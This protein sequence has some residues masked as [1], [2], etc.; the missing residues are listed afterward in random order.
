MVRPAQDTR[1]RRTRYAGGVRFCSALLASSILGAACSGDGA[2]GEPVQTG[3]VTVTVLVGG[4]PAA[5]E[6]VVF[7]DADGNVLEHLVTGSDGSGSVSRVIDRG[8]MV[9]AAHV[10]E[11]GDRELV[12]LANLAPLEDLRFEFFSWDEPVVTTAEISAELFPGATDYVAHYPCGLSLSTD[13]SFSPDLEADCL[14]AGGR[15]DVGVTAE[16]DVG[17]PVAWTVRT[18][19][20][21]VEAGTTTVAMPPWRSD[22]DAQDFEISSEPPT[23]TPGTLI[24]ATL[25][26]RHVEVASTSTAFSELPFSTSLPMLPPGPDQTRLVMLLTDGSWLIDIDSANGPFVADANDFLESPVMAADGFGTT[27]PTASW[28]GVPTA[29]LDATL[30]RLFWEPPSGDWNTWSV[31]RKPTGTGSLEFPALP[32]ALAAFRPDSAVEGSMSVQHLES[33]A[34]FGYGDVRRGGFLEYL[35]FPDASA[36]YRMRISWDEVDLP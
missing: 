25:V 2:A 28:A 14:D 3:L 34:F 19:V 27:R 8:D 35:D 16:D 12:T 29:S 1:N 9:T 15:F 18:N 5:G 33:T 24:A 23:S 7:H 30:V 32:D 4:L 6:D 36:H 17:V 10:D 22:F 13:P 26:Q 31:F 21:V 20:P 11:Y